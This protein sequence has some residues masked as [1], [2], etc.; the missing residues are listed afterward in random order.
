MPKLFGG[1]EM[2][3]IPK[4]PKPHN[5]EEGGCLVSVLVFVLACVFLSL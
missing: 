2:K 5:M 3:E 4:R 1:G